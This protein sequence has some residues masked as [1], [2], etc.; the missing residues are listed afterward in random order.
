MNS[1]RIISRLLFAVLL[2]ATLSSAEILDF[3]TNFGPEEDGATGS[4][5]GTFSFDTVA[6]TLAIEVNW[7]GLSGLTTVAHIHCCVTLAGTGSAGVAVTAPTLPGFPTDVS[8][9]IYSTILDLTLEGTY[10]GAF[11]TGAGGTAEAAS[12][13]LLQGILDGEAYFNIHS[14][15]YPPGEIRGFIVAVPEPATCLLVGL[16]LIALLRKRNEPSR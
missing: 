4:G 3:Y 11:L 12:A 13:A 9:G 7:S 5:S 15:E 6:Q 14:S 1:R 16:A 8:E 2:T 10:S